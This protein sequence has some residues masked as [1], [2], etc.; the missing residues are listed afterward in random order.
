MDRHRD[1]VL[2]ILFFSP[3]RVRITFAHA[4]GL[5]FIVWCAVTLAWTSS[6]DDGIGALIELVFIA[7]TFALGSI[8]DDPKPLYLGA[9]VGIA[10]SSCAVILEHLQWE[11][12]P[13]YDL[14]S[15]LFYNAVNMGEAAALVVVACAASRLWLGVLAAAPALLLSGSRGAMLA[16]AAAT[17]CWIWQQRS[18][19]RTLGAEMVG[20]FAVPL[21]GT[22][23]AAIGIAVYVHS[24]LRL[25]FHLATPRYLVRHGS[26]IDVLGPW[27]RQLL[28]RIPRHRARDRHQHQSTRA[29]PQ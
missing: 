25:D 20:I 3:S 18:N 19:P 16:V 8:T 13:S 15:G 1:R 4:A 28:D 24:G 2:S 9:A 26:R 17:M 11:T 12:L 10:V 22:V 21:I 5:A 23:A 6:L 29:R 14:P 27:S 7:A